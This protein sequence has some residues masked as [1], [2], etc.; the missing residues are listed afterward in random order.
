MK[1]VNHGGF[2]VKAGIR[3]QRCGVTPFGFLSQRAV[4]PDFSVSIDQEVARVIKRAEKRKDPAGT[5]RPPAFQLPA[6]A[7][8]VALPGWYFLCCFFVCFAFS[9]S[10]AGLSNAQEEIR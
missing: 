4:A 8:A 3:T 10:Q 6:L 1:G 7:E 2:G 9:F 5:A